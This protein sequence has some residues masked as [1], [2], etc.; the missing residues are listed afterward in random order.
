MA[1]FTIT[2]SGSLAKFL[3][4]VPATLCS[5]SLE[6]LVAKGGMLP[7]RRHNKDSTG[8][9]MKIATWPL[10][11]PHASKSTSKGGIPVLAGVTDSDY[12]GESPLQHGTKE[13]CVWNMGDLL[14]H[15]LL[16]TVPCT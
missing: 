5:V 12:N 7:P 11:D 15:L 4:P 14:G 13:E 2:P 16:F 10:W 3:L 8:V 6:V 1:P 9:D